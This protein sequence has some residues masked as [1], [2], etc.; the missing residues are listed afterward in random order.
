[1]GDLS[2]NNIMAA[3]AIYCIVT[4]DMVSLLGRPDRG[5][6]LEHRAKHMLRLERLL[7]SRLLVS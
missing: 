5:E 2:D 4:L 6:L 1:M 3:E 7:V